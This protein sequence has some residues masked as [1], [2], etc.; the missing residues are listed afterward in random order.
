ML[1]DRILASSRQLADPGPGL[2]ALTGG[3][4]TTGRRGVGRLRMRRQCRTTWSVQC[5]ETA[6]C[7]EYDTLRWNSHVAY[8]VLKFP[9]Q[10]G[11]FGTLYALFHLAVGAEIKRC[12]CLV[13]MCCR[14]PPAHWPSI[15]RYNVDQQRCT[16]NLS[17]RELF[18]M[19]EL[20]G[21]H[22]AGERGFLRA[23]QFVHR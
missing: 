3:E 1:A 5:R 22:A 18:N 14:T 12:R 7:E 11:K 8:R 20:L 15:T 4:A 16:K 23:S 17:G 19:D 13:C 2:A 9:V 6:S 21:H 10:L